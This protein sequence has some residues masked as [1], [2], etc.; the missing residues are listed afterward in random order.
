[1][2]CARGTEGLVEVTV[3]YTVG[4]V[5]YVNA[6]P[7]VSWFEEQG[8]ESPVKVLYDVPSRLP[9]LLDAGADAILVSSIDALS[10][11]RRMAAGV[12][13]G[14]DGP[15][16]SVRMFSKV[17]FGEIE[18]LALDVSSMTSN[19]LAQI[20][21]AETYG[22]TP[23][24]RQMAP[25]LDLMLQDNDACVLIGDIGMIANGSGLQVMD[26]GEAWTTMTGLPFLWAAWTG[27]DSL[28]PELASLLYRAAKQ[29]CMG[30]GAE[31]PPWAGEEDPQWVDRRRQAVLRRAMD[32][33]GWSKRMAEDYLRNVMV[34][35]LDERMLSGLQTFGDLLSKHQLLAEAHFPTVVDAFPSPVG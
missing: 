33:G 20:L 2:C 17:P 10:H 13:I 5:P 11:P 32:H 9:R 29:S 26:L 28:R 7:L 30:R 21:L 24:T 23:E 1:V 6:I 3:E 16:K 19:A 4:C 15:V 8:D 27:G 34:Y 25:S 31:A 14:S 35:D 12:C 22:I 18:T